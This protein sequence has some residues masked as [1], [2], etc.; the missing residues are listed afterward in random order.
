[1]YILL[2]STIVQRC[3]LYTVVIIRNLCIE[4]C[5]EVLEP[6]WVFLSF[7]LNDTYIFCKP[8]EFSAQFG[9]D[10]RSQI[11]V[12]YSYTAI[13]TVAMHVWCYISACGFNPPCLLWAVLEPICGSA[14]NPL[15]SGFP[16]SHL[17]VYSVLRLCFYV[18]LILNVFF[19]WDS[20][21][22]KSLL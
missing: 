3:W 13:N 9:I 8:S 22:K 19:V 5:S 6:Y 14:P 4:L 1:V 10:C 18:E 20:S 17:Y 21:W 12:I 11:C 7:N 2:W 15:C 16:R